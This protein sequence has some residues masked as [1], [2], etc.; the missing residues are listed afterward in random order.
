MK[1]NTIYKPLLMLSVA[2][3]GGFT[4]IA[5]TNAKPQNNK[6]KV[7]TITII[8]GDTTIKEQTIN[9]SDLKGLEKD[10]DALTGK[11]KNICIT[12]FAGMDKDFPNIDSLMK[13]INIEES[14]TSDGKHKQIKKVI[15]NNGDGKSNAYSYSFSDSESD[16]PSDMIIS[17]DGKTTIIKVDTSGGKSENI[18]INETKDG[19]DNKKVIVMSKVKVVNSTNSK[20]GL[21]EKPAGTEKELKMQKLNFYPNP[22]T[23]KFTLEFEATDKEPVKVSVTDITGK[24]VYS[25]TVKGEEKYKRTIELNSDSQGVYMINLTQGKLKTTRKIIVE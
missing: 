15:I 23:G 22:S 25:E 6:M 18:I 21:K 5:Q 2:A 14:N 19:K 13:N 12:A 24:E 7:K 20:S 1:T 16:T 3:L 4:A 8:D 17:N 10:L 11:N 9:E